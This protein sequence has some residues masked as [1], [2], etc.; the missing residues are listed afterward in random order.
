MTTETKPA[1]WSFSEIWNNSLLTFDQRILE[2]REHIYASEIGGP[3]ID[4]Y[5]KMQATKYSNPPNDRSMR[6]FQAGNIWE[7]I[8]GF[9]LRRA[10][11]N[12]LVQAKLENTLPGCLRV[13]GRLDFVA[14]GTPDWEKAESEI[15]L[16]DLPPFLQYASSNIISQLKAKYNG[17]NLELCVQEVK[18]C[19][20]FVMDRLDAVG[21]PSEHHHAQNFFYVMTYDKPGK[22]V[23][24]CRDDCRLKEFRIVKNDKEAFEFY[25]NDVEQMTYYFQKKKM[26][27]AEKELKF[28][29]GTYRFRHNF[30]I[31]YSPYL[32]LLYGYKT[33]D[34]FRKRWAS[35]ATQ[36]NRVFKRCVDC[37]TMTSA[38]LD[39]INEAKKSFKNWDQWVHDAKIAKAKGLL[40][41]A[42]E[43]VDA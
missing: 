2:P 30:W 18:S 35:T 41:E 39:V 22:L 31:E 24:V 1:I 43:E 15:L 4:R 42:G 23:Y 9:V 37:L 16:L 12:Q 19:S 25:K 17:A 34:E 14:G 13:S 28:E 29:E 10:G 11:I 3:F 33:P 8:I 21:K 26:P 7:W 20:S 40:Q 5:L 27:P 32:A 38:N 6:K 36:Y